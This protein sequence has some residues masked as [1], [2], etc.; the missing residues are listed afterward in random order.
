ME[1]YGTLHYIRQQRRTLD[2]TLPIIPTASE[3]KGYYI[4][5]LD[6]LQW[7]IQQQPPT[8][9]PSSEP[10]LLKLAFDGAIITSGKC[11][12]QELG[13]FQLLKPHEALSTIKS[14]QSCH[15]W[16]VYIGSETA[17]ELQRELQSTIKVLPCFF[18]KK[19]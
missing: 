13:S 16:I 12:K 7:H 3:G 10:L 19:R 5:L 8:P 14:P 11:T 17:E 15:V 4:P 18:L 9:T 6:F 1:G 2:T